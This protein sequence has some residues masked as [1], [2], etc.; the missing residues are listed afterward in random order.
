MRVLIILGL[1]GVMIVQKKPNH[2]TEQ[3]FVSTGA[4]QQGVLDVR[5]AVAAS[6]VGPREI[7]GSAIDRGCIIIIQMARDVCTRIINEL[8]GSLKQPVTWKAATCT[9]R[10]IYAKKRC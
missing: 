4:G 7:A 1:L 8:W 2:P 5:E 3:E 6:M 10:F 9:T